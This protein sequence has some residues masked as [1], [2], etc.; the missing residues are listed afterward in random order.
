MTIARDMTAQDLHL[1]AAEVAEVLTQL[2]GEDWTQAVAPDSG[3]TWPAALL[4][5]P[6]GARLKVQ[7]GFDCAGKVT[8][9]AL[10]PEGTYLSSRDPAHR[11][12]LSANVSP[13]RG[14]ATIART[15]S[16]A[17]LNGGYLDVLPG[18]L[19]VKTVNDAHAAERAS[20]LD[21]AAALFRVSR[22]GHSDKLY[23]S[24]FLAG[25][26]EVSVSGP[27][28]DQDQARMSL[29]LNGLP[30]QVGL[31][32][33]QVLA[34]ATSANCCYRF[35]PGHHPDLST[36]GCLREQSERGEDASRE[37]VRRLLAEHGADPER[38]DQALLYVRNTGRPTNPVGGTGMTPSFDFDTR[39]YTVSMP[40]KDGTS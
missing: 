40:R 28:A 35:G 32:M 1:L 5:G 11:I 29:E 22:T 27:Y 33:L 19:A 4:A 6:D 15:A 30:P 26:G 7:Y 31:D 38:A 18:L 39:E 16:R 37:R 12:R 21:Q 8:V 2:R 23:L 24:D 13:D 3:D 25:R 20:W 17:V 36:Y 10:L 14:G 9:T 34:R